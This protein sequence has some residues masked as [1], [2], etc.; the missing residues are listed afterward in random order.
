M[1][2]G[3]RPAGAG[4]TP[5]VGTTAD[6]QPAPRV[7]PRRAGPSAAAGASPADGRGHRAGHLLAGAVVLGA[8][9][10][11]ATAA[12]LVTPGGPSPTAARALVGV[13]AGVHLVALGVLAQRV[14]RPGERAIW[15]R[16]LLAAALLGG[17][18]APAVVV[19]TTPGAVGAAVLALA[20]GVLVLLAAQMRLL[21]VR[22]RT[23]GP[24]GWFDLVAGHLTAAAVVWALF[25][26][27]LRASTGLGTAQACLLLVPLAG[28]LLSLMFMLTST[29]VSGGWGD[30]RVRAVVASAA[31]LLG[32]TWWAVVAL[33][34][35]V[36]EDVLRA[37][38]AG[39]V[40]LAVL[41]L[42][43]GAALP[44]P[45]GVQ[46]RDEDQRAAGI[47]P[48]VLAVDC[49]VVL[50]VGQVLPVPLAAAGAA[51]LAVV[52][53]SAKV[54]VL[55]GTLTAYHRARQEADTDELTGLGNRRVLRERL[56]A[57]VAEPTAVALLD[58]DGFKAVNDTL[59]HDAGDELLRQVADRLRRATGP[60]E[61]LVRLGG[62]E[63]A[64]VLPGAGAGEA[65]A[66]ARAALA[67]LAAPFALEG[68][69]VEVGAS[70][71]VSATP[72]HGPGGGALLRRADAAMYAAKQQREGVVVGPP[73][74]G[75]QVVQPTT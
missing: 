33:T 5:L 57:S 73:R 44:P 45:R 14:R 25:V 46:R 53:V 42:A 37:G 43:L 17:A 63:F 21:Q 23:A 71:G 58:L 30:G 62:D 18:G 75:D 32:G 4:H 52:V 1:P 3:H 48:V 67:A 16:A 49:L 38:L 60:D 27:P 50:L 51:A 9:V 28:A 22:L 15:W 19:P 55:L 59:G 11:A 13:L 26:D 36:A 70:A 65:T 61:V 35:A 72:E 39:S 6:A 31:V 12:A 24:Y 47:G 29:T 40:V 2:P 69:D 64:V 10:V 7:R 8:A 41:L 74:D 20:L 56:D 54:V 68:G 34:S 66:R